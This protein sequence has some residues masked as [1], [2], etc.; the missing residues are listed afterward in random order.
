MSAAMSAA[1]SAAR[2]A[3]RSAA[4]RL[5]TGI[6]LPF[7]EAVEMGLWLYWVC[8]S[9][10]V[11]VPRPSLH[12]DARQR[13][14][15]EDGPAV[16]WGAGTRYYFWGGVQVS[17]KIIM[18][19]LDLTVPEITQ[20]RNAEVR[21]VMLTQYGEARYILDSGAKLIHQDRWGELYRQELTEDEPLVMVRVL[22]STPELDTGTIKPYFI[23]VP[24][25]IPTAHAAVAWTFGMQAKDYQPAYET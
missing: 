23:R 3:A 17:E 1:E 7:L 21:R 16:Y 19:P 20:E 22:N 2:S 4:I 25:D 13:L 11:A 24:P 10:V 18:H 5:Y 6:W 14:H 12:I 15:R 9:C 8:E